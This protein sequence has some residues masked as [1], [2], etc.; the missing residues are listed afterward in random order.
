MRRI[1]EPII[2]PVLH[3]PSA[4]P[5]W[6]K[7]AGKFA[8][9]TNPEGG[10]D[11]SSALAADNVELAWPKIRNELPSTGKVIDFGCGAGGFCE[12]LAKAGYSV[13]GIDPSL[14]MINVAIENAQGDITYIQ[15]SHE[16]LERF[17]ELDALT[18]TMV[19]QFLEHPQPVIEK[20][21][22]TVKEGG[23]IVITVVNPDFVKA[24]IAYGEHFF[25]REG[26][27]QI[28]FGGDDYAD[29]YVR[30][31]EDYQAMFAQ[32][33]CRL[34]KTIYPPFTPEFIEKYNWTLPSN[35]SEFMIMV[36]K[37]GDHSK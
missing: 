24:C 16:M 21:V 27:V 8:R 32:K 23:T 11:I 26:K 30:S 4:N 14:N 12:S 31:A 15:G 34:E 9:A 25:N 6:D 3:S 18:S 37:K 1:R 22:L 33:N 19:L 28:H 10:V 5:F 35:V 36:F 2:E 29:A 20:M 17:Q 13:V 7:Q